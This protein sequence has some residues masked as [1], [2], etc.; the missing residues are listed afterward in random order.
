MFLSLHVGVA[1][2]LA[3]KT[4]HLFP[5]N[6]YAQQAS[7]CKQMLAVILELAFNVVR[8]ISLQLKLK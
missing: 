2:G 8:P 5:G 1:L 4:Q 3:V 7:E 6:H